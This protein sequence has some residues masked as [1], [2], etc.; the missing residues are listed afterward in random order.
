[1]HSIRWNIVSDCLIEGPEELISHLTNLVRTYLIHGSIPIPKALLVCSLFPQ[2]KNKFRDLTLSDNYSTIARGSLLLKI[3]KKVIL[4]LEGSKLGF[5][6]LQFAYQAST[7][8]CSR[9]VTSVIDWFN[10][11]GSSV[12][13]A[14]MDMSKAFDNVEWFQ[15]FVELQRRKVGSIYLELLLYIY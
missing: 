9:A 1:M 13:M 6:E 2:V 8:V 5:S 7:S 4:M 14:T 11:N 10:R 12:Y 3:L 15:L